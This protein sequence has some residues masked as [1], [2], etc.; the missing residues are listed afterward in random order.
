M[1]VDAPSGGGPAP[2]R[3][4]SRPATEANN[5][6]GP[7]EGLLGYAREDTGGVPS[8]SQ[9]PPPEAGRGFGAGLELQVHAAVLDGITRQ[10]RPVRVQGMVTGIGR[11]TG[12]RPGCRPG[13]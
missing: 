5:G 2:G 7:D 13:P 1:P 8:W 4:D 12:Q 10:G 11:G 6:G 3:Y 9:R